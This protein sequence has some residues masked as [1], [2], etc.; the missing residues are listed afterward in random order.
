MEQVVAI[1]LEI[2]FHLEAFPHVL[3]HFTDIVLADDLTLLVGEEGL[4]GVGGLAGWPHHLI[5]NAIV[6]HTRQALRALVL[7]VFI[8]VAESRLSLMPRRPVGLRPR[9]FLLASSFHLSAIVYELLA[10]GDDNESMLIKLEL[11]AVDFNI[12]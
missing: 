10:L 5:P 11:A 8:C 7:L 4:G 6:G 2:S 12:H 3:V 9:H 1:L